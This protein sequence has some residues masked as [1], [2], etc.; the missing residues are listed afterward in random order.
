MNER[1]VSEIK[2]R[3]V[4]RDCNDLGDGGVCTFCREL[5]TVTIVHA[6]RQCLGPALPGDDYC[7]RYPRCL[8]PAEQSKAKWAGKMAEAAEAERIR[9]A[10]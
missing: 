9:G 7:N 5:H 8:T 4:S 3:I 10:R 2:G 1:D 6:C